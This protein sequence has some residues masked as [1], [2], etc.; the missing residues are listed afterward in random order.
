MNSLM[1]GIF[2]VVLLAVVALTA[3]AHEQWPL[4]GMLDSNRALTSVSPVLGDRTYHA[5][6][7]ASRCSRRPRR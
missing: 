3:D 7:S 1:Y 6:I 4:G 2:A 5:D